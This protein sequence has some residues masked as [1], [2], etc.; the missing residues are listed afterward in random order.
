MLT[1]IRGNSKFKEDA[2]KKGHKSKAKAYTFQTTTTLGDNTQ[3]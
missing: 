2:I 1:S 3:F